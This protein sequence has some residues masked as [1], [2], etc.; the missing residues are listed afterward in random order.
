M[1]PVA[2][3]THPDQALAPILDI[4]FNPGR[5]RIQ[6]IFKQFLEDGSGPLHDFASGDL[7]DKTGFQGMNA[8][9]FALYP[10]RTGFSGNQLPRGRYF[11]HFSH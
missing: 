1:D 9:A 5:G 10:Q 11:Q 3:I 7:V 8:H 4:N 2:V 6:T